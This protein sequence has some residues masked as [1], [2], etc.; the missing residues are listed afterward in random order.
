MPVSS[1]PVLFLVGRRLLSVWMDVISEV[2]ALLVII[3]GSPSTN[4]YP[5]SEL[6]PLARGRI[7]EQHTGAHIGRVRKEHPQC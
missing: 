1:L 2:G 3:Q 6:K 4:K 5:S 7:S